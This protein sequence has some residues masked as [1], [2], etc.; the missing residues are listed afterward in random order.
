MSTSTS[1]SAASLLK[2]AVDDGVLGNASMM[3]FQVPNLGAQ[4]QAGLGVAVDDVQASEV[5]LLALLVDDSGSIRFGQNAQGIRDGVNL[6]YEA[7]TQSKSGGAVLASCRYLNGTILDAYTPIDQAT[8]LDAK[9]YNPMGGTPLYDESVVTLGTV[10][11]KTQEF[12]DAG[13]PARTV[14]VILSDGA[15]LHSRLQTSDSVKAVVGDMLLA[16]NHLVFFV[17]VDDGCT[18]FTFVAESMGIPAAFV[19]TPGNS[20]SEIRAAMAVVSRS[21]VR[22]SQ[23]GAG[24]SQAAASGLGGFG[25]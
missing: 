16:E 14:T 25:T 1:I 10:V 12:E 24:F 20:P 13:V 18:N 22:A 2:G 6:V 17:G 4:I 11:A 7:L 9:N 19:L 5:F 3:A 21:V 8:R 15:D 23:G